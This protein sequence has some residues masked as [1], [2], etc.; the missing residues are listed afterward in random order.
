MT[1]SLFGYSNLSG[2][3]KKA[4]R[5]E[6]NYRVDDGKYVFEQL[7]KDSYGSV[8][9]EYSPIERNRWCRSKWRVGIACVHFPTVVSIDRLA[10]WGVYIRRDDQKELEVGKI[11]SRTALVTYSDILIWQIDFP[12]D[13]YR[14]YGSNWTSESVEALQLEAV[15]QAKGNSEFK[16][17]IQPDEIVFVRRPATSGHHD[18]DHSTEELYQEQV[19]YFSWPEFV[20]AGSANRRAAQFVLQEYVVRP[21]RL[22][23]AKLLP[24]DRAKTVRELNTVAAY[25]L[26]DNNCQDFS[27]LLMGLMLENRWGDPGRLTKPFVL[28]DLSDEWMSINNSW[29]RE[30]LKAQK[31]SRRGFLYGI[32]LIL[33]RLEAPDKDDLIKMGTEDSRRFW[34]RLPGRPGKAPEE[35]LR[36]LDNCRLAIRLAEAYTCQ[37][38]IST[39]D[40]IRIL[41]STETDPVVEHVRREFPEALESHGATVRAWFVS[42]DHISRTDKAAWDLLA[43]ISWV[44][45]A[46]IPKTLLP[47][48]ESGSL[49]NTIDKLVRY[50]L[51]KTRGAKHLEMHP[52]LHYL[53][54]M[55][56]QKAGRGKE[57]ILKAIRHVATNF[58]GGDAMN[59]DDW[60]QYGSHLHKLY[61]NSNGLMNQEDEATFDVAFLIGQ[62]LLNNGEADIAVIFLKEAFQWRGLRLGENSPKLLESQLELA[63]AYAG[64]K[65][66]HLVVDMLQGA[67]PLQQFLTKGRP[68]LSQ[69]LMGKKPS[70][71]TPRV[72]DSLLIV[73]NLALELLKAFIAL[74]KHKEAAKVFSELKKADPASFIEDHPGWI[75][76]SAELLRTLAV[77]GNLKEEIRLREKI[78][79]AENHPERLPSKRRQVIALA[80]AYQENRQYQEAIDL[81]NKLVPFT[82]D[83][84]EELELLGTLAVVWQYVDMDKARAL[85]PRLVDLQ[86]EMNKQKGFLD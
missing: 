44:Q 73:M 74:D 62:G 78:L 66:S 71:K 13:I 5:A 69:R 79:D 55:G 80:K 29:S 19:M 72:D 53:T 11:P 82:T 43:F 25:H 15:W 10:H 4:H 2:P 3:S 37:R 9:T 61:S 60:E 65:H 83:P 16:Q 54:Q 32:P 70:T 42:F 18:H 64:N 45:P 38:S 1:G 68:S 50:R 63:K 31:Q 21:W 84:K 33:D 47:K 24:S 51:V 57:T 56:I 77:S 30:A 23:T 27:R 8:G 67:K 52:L 36:K 85:K 40:Y 48:P 86:K 20:L 12:N 81:L 59:R 75:A 39:R 58:S 6:F 34:E 35:L 17:D 49:N 22:Q 46:Y 76:H 7:V 26:L 28:D 41:D 14:V